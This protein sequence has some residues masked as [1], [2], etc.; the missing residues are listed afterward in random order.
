MQRLNNILSNT[1]ALVAVALMSVGC[2]LEKEEASSQMQEVMIELS[3]SAGEM[4]KASVATDES[5]VSSLRIYA[6]YGNRLAGYAFRGALAEGEPFYMDLK[7]PETG[8]HN[9][10]FY[11]VANEKEMDF[12][13]SPVTL[14]ENMTRSQLEGIRFTRLSS[15]SVI[16]MYCRQTEPINVDQLKS[17]MNSESGHEGHYFLAQKINFNLSR[18]LAK[19]SLHAAKAQ[20]ADYTPKILSATLLAQGTRRYSYLF[21]QTDQVLDAVPS[22]VNDIVLLDSPVSI[23]KAVEKGSSAAKEASSYDMVTEAYTAEVACG[24]SDWSVSSGNPSELVIHVEYALGENNGKIE[25][26]YVYMPRIT[27]NTHYKVCVLI[28]AEG[29]ISINYEVA[30]WDDNVMEPIVFDYPTHSY[31]HESISDAISERL[32][33][34]KAEATMSETKPFVG[35]FQMTY[36]END[37]WT[38]TLMGPHAGNCDVAVYEIEGIEERKLSDEDWPIQAS[39]HWYKIEVKP[40]PSKIDNGDEVKL[41]VTYRAAGFETIE[42]LLINGSYQEYYWPYSGTS[43]QDANYVIITMVN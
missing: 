29:K 37:S 39:N 26:G 2:L 19:V 40:D 11:L 5:A 43:Q 24:S 10:D 7:L 28:N 14:S 36:P 8:I 31:L 23:S 22:R 4:T 34:P 6:F 35:Y 38:P 30:P 15:K 32:L 3:V 21:P 18:S 25:N 12:E 42:Y 16:P 17:E 33:D 13:N 27:R 20:G 41:A 1:I 9:V